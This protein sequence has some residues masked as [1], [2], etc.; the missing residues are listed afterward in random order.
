MSLP[1]PAPLAQSA[2][3]P[4][5]SRGVDDNRDKDGRKLVPPLPQPPQPQSDEH[6]DW[7][8]KNN[9]HGNEYYHCV[10]T[11][12]KILELTDRNVDDFSWRAS[13]WQSN[14]HQQAICTKTN[15]IFI[16]N[17]T[18]GPNNVEY[19]E[20]DRNPCPR[21]HSEWV[22]QTRRVGGCI[23]TSYYRLVSGDVANLEWRDFAT[24]EESNVWA[25]TSRLGVHAKVL[26]SNGLLRHFQNRTIQITG[27]CFG[28]YWFSWLIQH[29]HKHGTFGQK[30]SL[31]RD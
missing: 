20:V 21:K 12:A 15:R 6:G 25:R 8:K 11:P 30:I 22:S 23:E 10:V 31:H 19:C 14:Q 16:K 26:H 27:R 4:D 9:H 7:V 28:P 13:I 2:P 17:E 29:Q 24:G 3:T 18:N 5:D 1:Q